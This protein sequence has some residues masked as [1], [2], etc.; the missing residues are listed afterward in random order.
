ML[1]V[2]VLNAASKS[3][4]FIVFQSSFLAHVAR[5]AE[6][7]RVD[8]D[9]GATVRSQAACPF[10]TSQLAVVFVRCKNDFCLETHSSGLT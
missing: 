1:A 5:Q 8:Q 4:R 7:R 3:S 6:A 10:D 9:K 2:E